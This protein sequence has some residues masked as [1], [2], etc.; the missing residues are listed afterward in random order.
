M[1][2]K[3][4]L[5]KWCSFEEQAGILISRGLELSGSEGEDKDDLV[6][7]LS[8]YNYY[9]VTGYLFAHLRK[10]GKYLDEYD[11]PLQFERIREILSFDSVLRMLLLFCVDLIEKDLR[12]KI[13]Y[14]LGEVYGPDGYLSKE[15]FSS[16]KGWPKAYDRFLEI[17]EHLKRVNKDN[18]FVKHHQEKYGG[19]MPIWVAVEIMP[20]GTLYHLFDMS[21]I[22]IKRRV[23]QCFRVSVEEMESWMSCL[24]KYRNLFAHNHRL[25]RHDLPVQPRQRGRHNLTTRKLFSCLLVM[26][27]LFSNSVNVDVWNGFVLGVIESMIKDNT[28][29]MDSCYGIPENWKDVLFIHT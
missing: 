18:Q 5:K 28:L 8:C 2:Y 9:Y 14:F 15:N 19:T 12:T 26:K 1:A 20:L 10:N 17:F 25:Y 23:S 3:P 27:Y 22:G 16:G 6:K 11:R 4:E 7:F 29:N 24:V 21:P 13:A